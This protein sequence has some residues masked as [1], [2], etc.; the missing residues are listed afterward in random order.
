MKKKGCEIEEGIVDELFDIRYDVQRFTSRRSSCGR[1]ICCEIR[2]RK[3]NIFLSIMLTSKPV[4]AYYAWQFRVNRM[5]SY[6]V[7]RGAPIKVKCS[8]LFQVAT[9]E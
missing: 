8:Q 3:Q 6:Q 7:Q 9:S 4:H 2:C 5:F 1:K